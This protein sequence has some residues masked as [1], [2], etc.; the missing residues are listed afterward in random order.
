MAVETVRVSDKSREPIPEGTGARVRILFYDPAKPDMRADLTDA[1]V[2]KL[3]REYKLT[4]AEVRTR[5][6]PARGK[7]IKL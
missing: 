3:I 2:A 4:E 7:N 5:K 1:E 6:A